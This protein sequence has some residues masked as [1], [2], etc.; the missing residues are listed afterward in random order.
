MYI[1]KKSCKET[2]CAMC[3]NIFVVATNG[4]IFPCVRFVAD[5]DDAP[6]IIGNINKGLYPKK[7]LEIQHFMQTDKPECKDC[8][9]KDRCLGN[10]C[11]CISYSITGS[12][13]GL[14]PLVC[15][16]ERAVIGIAD[17]IGKELVG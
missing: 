16:H 5:G 9:I 17:K 2:T 13:F 14:S 4:N 10:S 12:L 7:L 3:E 11:G 6:Y 8:T 1:S 15:E